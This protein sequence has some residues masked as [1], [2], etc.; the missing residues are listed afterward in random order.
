M[1][2][3]WISGKRKS[4]VMEPLGVWVGASWASERAN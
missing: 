1:L 2:G 4:F 3:E